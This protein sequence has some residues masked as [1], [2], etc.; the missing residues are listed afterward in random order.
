MLYEVDKHFE[1]NHE[2]N[3]EMPILVMNE[4]NGNSQLPLKLHLN[5]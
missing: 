5:Q 1:I 3:E 2:I 4:M